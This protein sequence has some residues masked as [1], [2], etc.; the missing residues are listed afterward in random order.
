MR[1]GRQKL[2]IAIALMLLGAGLGMSMLALTGPRS[3]Q[4]AWAS[5]LASEMDG[6]WTAISIDGKALKPERYRISIRADEVSGGRDDC[7]DWGYAEE[8]DQNG[9]RMITSTLVGCP[10]G[11]PIRETYWALVYDP[12]V[13]QTPDGRLRVRGHGH[14]AIL[15]RCRWRRVQETLP[16]GGVSDMMR[17]LPE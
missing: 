3:P 8:R 5:I 6:D 17:C 12:Q 1:L 15:I 16:G 7:N 10:K 4:E 13:D 11:D 14:E 2:S 9:E